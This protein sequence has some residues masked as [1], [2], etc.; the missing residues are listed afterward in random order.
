MTDDELS[1]RL[2][3]AYSH[4]AAATIAPPPPVGEMSDRYASVSALHQRP[5]RLAMVGTLAAAAA[6]IA[7]VIFVGN[8]S[9]PDVRST[10]MPDYS[11]LHHL[12]LWKVPDGYGYTGGFIGPHGISAAED[13]T[14]VAPDGEGIS[15]T[16]PH[17]R[18][19]LLYAL[20]PGDPDPRV[21]GGGSEPTLGQRSDIEAR[22]RTVALWTYPDGHHSIDW[23][24]TDWLR[25]IAILPGDIDPVEFA[26]S[27]VPLNDR[28]A[29]QAQARFGFKPVQE[30]HKLRAVQR[31]GGPSHVEVAFD[32]SMQ[33]GLHWV[34]DNGSSVVGWPTGGE[35]VYLTRDP[36][37]PIRGGVGSVFAHPGH[38]GYYIVVTGADP[39]PTC[40]EMGM[41]S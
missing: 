23:Q 19:V 10:Q 17:G 21:E 22:G 32:G 8:R 11:T 38:P 31:S 30:C 14:F 25:V 13:G 41:G 20:K 37:A 35:R 1:E 3:G 9:T 16:G 36:S 18:Q 27:V 26:N 15:Y 28:Q 6:V 29:E 40:R 4:V 24:E 12:A 2:R 39:V 5:R 33:W 34:I 7:A